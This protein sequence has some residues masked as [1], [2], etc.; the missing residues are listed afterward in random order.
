MKYLLLMLLFLNFNVKEV[1]NS[2]IA[3]YLE[4]DAIVIYPEIYYAY[5]ITPTLHRHEMIHIDQ[6]NTFGSIFFYIDYLLQYC[7]HRLYMDHYNAYR[8]ISYEIEAYEEY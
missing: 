4:V 1:P 5:E 2:S 8:T 7:N 6:I 3:R